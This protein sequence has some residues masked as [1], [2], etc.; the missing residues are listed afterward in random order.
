MVA[1]MAKAFIRSGALAESSVMNLA[2][3][4]LIHDD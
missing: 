1:I 4:I 3:Q 2:L